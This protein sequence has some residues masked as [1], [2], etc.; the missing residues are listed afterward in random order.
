M[1]KAENI[2]C[3]KAKS[4]KQKSQ[5]FLPRDK[6]C[7]LHHTRYHIEDNL[8]N[9]NSNNSENNNMI[10]IMLIIHDNDV[11]KTVITVVIDNNDKQK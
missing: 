11:I 7:L 2:K 10:T 9:I 6:M 1:V 8:N 5:K 4:L 3:H